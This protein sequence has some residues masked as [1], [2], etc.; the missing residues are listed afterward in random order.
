MPDE[1][2]FEVSESKASRAVPISLEQAGLREREHLQEWV[3]GGAGADSYFNLGMI[4]KQACVLGDCLAVCE[5]TGPITQVLS[6]H[7]GQC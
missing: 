7:P 2:V 1:I 4:L 3:V 5:D 6:Q